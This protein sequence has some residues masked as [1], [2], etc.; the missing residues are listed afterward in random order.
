MPPI[1]PTT[2]PP[3]PPPSPPSPNPPPVALNMR[4]IAISE[5]ILSTYFLP[6]L[7]MDPVYEIVGGLVV[8][9]DVDPDVSPSELGVNTNNNATRNRL[10]AEYSARGRSSSHLAAC[11]T[12][13]RDAPFPCRT[14]VLPE[15]CLDG[16]RKCS[17]AEHNGDAPFIELDFH[18]TDQKN[19]YPHILTM[20]IPPQEEYGKL[21]F[22]SL[23]NDIQENRGWRVELFDK[24]HTM[25]EVP[26]QSWN[27]GANVAEHSEGLTTVQHALFGA[28][29]SD[30]TYA[31][32]SRARFL[33]VTL[34][35]QLR[36]IWLE[37][38]ELFIRDVPEKLV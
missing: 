28:I 2:L 12:Q 23:G 21:L 34:L 8:G 35:G 26:V 10:I 38:I 36:Q 17:T 22:H 13:L 29:T 24:N 31:A 25:I 18:A 20:R 32:A 14:S 1:A 5:V 3:P 9:L 30:A 37:N 16:D 15:R 7:R 11:T 27:I 6:R 33:R 4:Q 19:F